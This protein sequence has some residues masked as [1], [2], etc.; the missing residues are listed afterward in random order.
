M[1]RLLANDF[2]YNEPTGPT[3][4]GPVKLGRQ[5]REDAP[6]TC[7]GIRLISQPGRLG[8]RVPSNCL[9]GKIQTSEYVEH[10]FVIV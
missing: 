9:S 7:L 1:L 2:S 5:D 4:A 3:V 8:P 10:F 6:R